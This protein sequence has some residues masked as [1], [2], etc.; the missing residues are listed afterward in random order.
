MMADCLG[1]RVPVLGKKVIFSELV[2]TPRKLE[3]GELEIELVLTRKIMQEDDFFRSFIHFC[4]AEVEQVVV[5][6]SQ[7][8]L[9][10]KEEGLLVELVVDLEIGVEHRRIEVL[11]W[12]PP[13]PHH[14]R[15]YVLE[16]VADSD[17]ETTAVVSDFTRPVKHPEV[18]FLPR[19]HVV[20]GIFELNHPLFVDVRVRFFELLEVEGILE[21][22]HPDVGEAEGDQN[23]HVQSDRDHRQLDPVGLRRDFALDGANRAPDYPDFR[24]LSV[25]DTE[26]SAHFV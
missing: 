10:S 20:L 24:A 17:G 18:L 2:R 26:K 23:G 1:R 7:V 12:F 9:L 8:L 4:V 15:L 22:G 6:V 19:H 16:V 3:V 25:S 13:D 14:Q 21:G 11:D 5:E